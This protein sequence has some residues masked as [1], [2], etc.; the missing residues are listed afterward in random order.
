MH[1]TVHGWRAILLVHCKAHRTALLLAGAGDK[2]HPEPVKARLQF[3]DERLAHIA[4]QLRPG[5]G[6]RVFAVLPFINGFGPRLHAHRHAAGRSLAHLEA[7][8]VAAGCYLGVLADYK[9]K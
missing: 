5:V 2:D 8:R 4:V 3:I 7:L 1:R 9:I 6:L